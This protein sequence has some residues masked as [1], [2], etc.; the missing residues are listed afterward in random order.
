MESALNELE[1]VAAAS[2]S[3]LDL[4]SYEASSITTECT[5]NIITRFDLKGWRN[6]IG[7]VNQSPISVYLLPK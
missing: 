2:I 5:M 1:T 6:R 3:A 7:K 4:Y